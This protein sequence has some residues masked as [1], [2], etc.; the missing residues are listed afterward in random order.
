M[1]PCFQNRENLAAFHKSRKALFVSGELTISH[2]DGR[3]NYATPL[4]TVPQDPRY[5]FENGGGGA[6]FE[7]LL[8]LLLPYVP[9]RSAISKVNDWEMTRQFIT[10]SDK[11]FIEIFYLKYLYLQILF[12][13]FSKDAF[14][15]WLC[16]DKL[17]SNIYY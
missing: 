4:N 11:I 14:S 15:V 17:I 2:M 12:D 9:T 8:G 6:I 16:V 3:Q 5:D 13:K 7:R 10:L 1:N